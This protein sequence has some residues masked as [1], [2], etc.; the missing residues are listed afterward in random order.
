MTLV[1]RGIEAEELEGDSAGPLPWLGPAPVWDDEWH[2]SPDLAIHALVDALEGRLNAAEALALHA[3]REPA[4]DGRAGQPRAGDLALALVSAQ[5]GQRA[6]LGPTAGGIPIRLSPLHIVEV[7]VRAGL[8]GTQ[9]LDGLD[10]ATAH[11]PLVSMALTALGALDVVDVSG[12]RVVVGGPAEAAVRAARS[13]FDRGHHGAVDDAIEPWLEAAPSNAHPRTLVEAAVVASASAAA[14]RCH[15]AAAERLEL[16]LERAAPEGIWSP[17]TAYAPAI[18]DPLLT[19]ARESR[20]HQSAAITLL[21]R[22]QPMERPA[23][24]E[25][26][27]HQECTVLRFLPTLRSNYEIGD[28]MNLSVNTVKVHLKAIYRKLGVTN[29]RDAVV[30]ARQLDLL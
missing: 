21:D 30:Q 15:R 6:A 7:A 24:V 2:R 5:R 18:S 29:R 26:L 23:Y 27:T 3:G 10:S 14:R 17:F 25:P 11:H 12:T 22:M 28:A 8:S 19:V 13:T 1:V 4:G 9:H 20:R 16:A